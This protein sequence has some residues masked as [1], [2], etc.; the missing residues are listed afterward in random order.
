MGAKLRGDLRLPV[1][2][3]VDR[4]RLLGCP[5]R[6]YWAGEVKGFRVYPLPQAVRER[7]LQLAPAQAPPER[8]PLEPEL[9]FSRRALARFARVAPRLPQAQALAEATSA[10]GLQPHQEQVVARL[11]DEYPRSWLVAD[12]VGLGKTISAGMALRRLLLAGEI[13]RALILAPANVCRQWQDEL[14]EKFGLWVPRLEGRKLHGAHPDD[15]TE[16]QPGE[17]PYAAAPVLIASS[18]LARRAEHHERVIAA[19]PYDLLIVDEAHHARQKREPDRY[20]P[21]RLL[22]LLDRVKDAD[23]A[24]ATWLLTATP[25]Q[26]EQLELRDLLIHVGLSGR[27]GDETGFMRYF[28]ELARPERAPPRGVDC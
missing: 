14:F 21:G 6:A 2:E 4:L 22:Q 3:Q 26:V 17:N 28:A 5:L 18:H 27:L 16:V 9:P 23:A 24:R 7:L 19:G 11:A 12:E 8:D 10:V 1:L 15:V 13:Q 20:R 25:M